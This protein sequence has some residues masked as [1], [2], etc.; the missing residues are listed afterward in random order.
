MPKVPC[1]SSRL[2]LEPARRLCQSGGL[3]AAVGIVS[4]SS[5]VTTQLPAGA[6]TSP[7]AGYTY[8]AL[9]DSFTSGP[10]IPTQTAGG[11]DRSTNDY[12]AD[13]ASAL[14]LKLTD[15]SCSGATTA[16]VINTTEVVSPGPNNPPQLSSLSSGTQIVSLQIGGNDLGFTSI[17]ENCVALTPWGPTKVGANCRNYYGTSLANYI[18]TTLTTNV[19]DILA[20]V[21][22]TDP[23]GKV[24]VVGYPDILPQNGACWPS[25][26]FETADAEY[27]NGVEQDLNM[28]LAAQAKSAGATY[29]D[30]YTPSESYNACTSKSTRWVEPLVPAS[31]ADPFH[32]NA[33]G[34]AQMAL[35]LEK[36]IQA[37]P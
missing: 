17:I 37:N 3:L 11:C 20:Q 10:V 36:A 9:G 34:E 29:V 27:L 7:V 13:T 18:S 15:V 8:L 33:T 1:P 24:F 16:N 4:V 35:L 22:T 32:P 23:S 28:M 25:M 26:P 14:S 19:G 5:A 30:T 6:T 12:P 31:P 2:L 21:H